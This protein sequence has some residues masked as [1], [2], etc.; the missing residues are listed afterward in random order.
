MRAAKCQATINLGSQIWKSL[1][2]SRHSMYCAN[3][4]DAYVL[5][6]EYKLKDYVNKM[7]K[8]MAKARAEV[9]GSPK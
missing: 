6:G 5:Q 7:L 9:R 2:D 8:A 1:E 3:L 4:A